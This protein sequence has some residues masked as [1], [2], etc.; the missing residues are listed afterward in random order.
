MHRRQ[1]ILSGLAATAGASGL[2]A[3]A[4]NPP[5]D[6]NFPIRSDQT[7]PAYTSE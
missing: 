1:L 4:T 2:S 3:C 7:A 6:P 5:S